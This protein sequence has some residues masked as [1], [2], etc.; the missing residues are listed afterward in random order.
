MRRILGLHDL[1]KG[2]AAKLLGVSSQ[3]V[4]EWLSKTRREG[5]RLPN[6]QTLQRVSTFFD[7]PGDRLAW[8]PFSELL[9][10]E[11]ADVDRFDKVEQK[12]RKGLAPVKAAPNPQARTDKTK[13]R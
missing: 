10:N 13:G 12:I 7:I 8:T 4:S 9:P 3:A 6:L 5:T 1:E 2:E 11:L